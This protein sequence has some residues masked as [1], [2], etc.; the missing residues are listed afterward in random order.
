MQRRKSL[1]G[2]RP[3]GANRLVLGQGLSPEKW[4]LTFDGEKLDLHCKFWGAEFS[5]WAKRIAKPCAAYYGSGPDEK[6]VKLTDPEI[7]WLAERLPLWA[8]ERHS[9]IRSRSCSECMF[10]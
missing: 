8:C 5:P 6:G 10:L 3:S 9:R 4:T 7:V 1:A 2:P